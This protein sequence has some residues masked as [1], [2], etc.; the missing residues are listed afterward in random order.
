MRMKPYC[1][2]FGLA[3]LLTIQAARAATFTVTNT[4]DGGLGSLNSAILSNNATAGTITNTIAFN[5]LP[6]DGTVKTI[7]VTNQLPP[8]THSVIIDGYTQDPTHSH[9]NTL[10]N[11]DDAVL[12][13]ELNGTNVG[14]LNGLNFGS[15]SGASNSVVRGLVIN[16]FGA[17]AIS[18]QNQNS[19]IV[20]EGNFIGTDPTGKLARGNVRTT[21]LVAAIY[22]DCPG[23]RIGGTS[24]GARNIISGNHTGGILTGGAG[25]NLIQGNFIGVDATGTNALGNGVGNG[26]HG[27]WLQGSSDAVGGTNAGARN[28]ISGNGG[29]GVV[30]NQAQTVRIRD[31]LVQGNY[32]GTDANGTRLLPNGLIGVEVNESTNV[33]IGGAAAVAGTPP[34]NVIAGN[35]SH[36]VAV[37]FFAFGG[38]FDFRVQG[39]IVTANQ[40]DGVLI[41]SPSA[42]DTVSSN[43]IFANGGLGIELSGNANNSQTNPVITSVTTGGGNVTLAGSLQSG[44]NAV[45]RLEFFSNASCDGSGFG[46]G[47]VF[48]GSTNVTT[49]ASGNAGFSLTLTN[50]AGHA[51]FTATAT[52]TNGNTSAFSPCASVSGPCV[53]TCPSN[54]V[55]FAAQNQ[56]S[57]VVNFF[58]TTSGNCG[59]VNC[60]PP[61][62]SSFS[63]GTNTVTCTS[64]NGTNCS[65]TITVK[66]NIP[67]VA[68]CRNV[69]TNAN[70]SCQADVPAT[71][72]DNG[73]SDADG[74]I[75]NFTLTPPGPYAKGT[76]AVTLTVTDDHG[77][78]ATCGANIV[79]VDTTG[80]AINCP[81]NIVTNAPHGQT[82]VAVNYTLPSV[83]DNCS[84]TTTTNCTPTSGS[85]F[86]LGVTTVTCIATDASGNTN[87]CS[88]TVTVNPTPATL[89]WS[90]GGAN[91]FWTNAANW[92]G[93]IAPANGDS[94]IFPTNAARLVNTNTAG[95]PNS[96]ASITL[97]GS[98]Y[99]IFSPPLTLVGGLTNTSPSFRSN[100]LEAAINLGADQ[101]WRLASSAG[102]LT[103]AS[104]LNLS[105]FHLTLT[106]I[107]TLE[108]LGNISGSAGSQLVLDNPDLKLN[109]S[110]NDVPDLIVSSGSLIVDGVLSGGLTISLGGRLQGKGTVP[111]FTCAGSFIPGGSFSPGAMTVSS[112]AA[113]F[114]SGSDFQVDL[115]G[116]TT[117][118][119]NYDQL[120]VSSPPDLSGAALYVTPSYSAAVGETYVIIT[121]TGVAPFTTTFPGFPEGSIYVISSPAN[122]FRISYVGGDG[123]DV[124]LRRVPLGTASAP[125]LAIQQVATNAVRLLWPTNPPGFSLEC[126]TNLSGTNWQAASPSPTVTGT[127]NVATNATSQAAK[128]YRLKK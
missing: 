96:L 71:A 61:S 111:A 38:A 114:T 75:V 14:G 63:I 104:N 39:N 34:G 26:L 47:Q 46:E 28:V 109:G 78:T 51:N 10:A 40:G 50:P 48:L 103:L 116:S 83:T 89:T 27:V 92:V 82:N 127:N 122:E 68:A 22:L 24:T 102:T 5:I 43:S 32:I 44:S 25:N 29:D 55:V 95:G 59:A 76:N 62:G 2:F 8:I 67:P 56:S 49:D 117:P 88:F 20:I 124:T 54:I 108:A 18:S 37:G 128:F 105:T 79:V 86:P 73:S 15:G 9:T 41:R 91:S 87:S 70:A 42:R 6:L 110:A 12:L 52:D 99:V 65:F 106:P 101:V 93:N 33:L 16:N 81:A 100:R 113:T 77:A 118:G 85:L 115:F 23:I 17:A 120:K 125:R 7:F 84:G 4:L 97:S 90:G 19:G 60:T 126:N 74:S 123:N 45:F 1:V 36:G 58:P 94:L 30:V 57:A 11:A 121:N 107:G 53:I 31:V 112:G 13:I 21:A 3:L 66:S 35:S 80:P 64:A 69:T 98:N 72:V 119:I